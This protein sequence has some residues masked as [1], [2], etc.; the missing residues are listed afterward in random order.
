M[1]QGSLSLVTFGAALIALGSI[2]LSSGASLHWDGTRVAAQAVR[3]G[4]VDLESAAA[5][6]QQFNDDRGNT[7]LVLLLSPT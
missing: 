4:L 7:R 3:A 2:A 5:L 6:R 1:A